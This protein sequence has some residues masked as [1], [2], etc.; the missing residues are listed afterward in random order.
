MT[1]VTRWKLQ[2][3]QRK[4]DR[5]ISNIKKKKNIDLP[6]FPLG[7]ITYETIFFFFH[8]VHTTYYIHVL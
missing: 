1:D 3:E 5:L 6:S 2:G 7:D 8:P 4:S